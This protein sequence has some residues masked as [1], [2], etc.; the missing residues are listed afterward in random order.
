MKGG[1]IVVFKK[2]KCVSIT[3]SEYDDIRF[4]NNISSCSK[5]AVENVLEYL[6]RDNKVNQKLDRFIL[7]EIAYNLYMAVMNDYKYMKVEEN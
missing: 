1:F 7:L 3:K 5:E 2:N 4:I 6:V